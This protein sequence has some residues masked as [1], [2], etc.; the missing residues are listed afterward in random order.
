MP[1]SRAECDS[2]CVCRVK[3]R[4]L[5]MSPMWSELMEL[6]AGADLDQ[7]QEGWFSFSSAERVRNMFLQ[8][9]RDRN[10]HLSKQEFGA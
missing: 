8:L 4:D 5:V 10:N 6:R 1:K 7:P 3:I 9:D 2:I